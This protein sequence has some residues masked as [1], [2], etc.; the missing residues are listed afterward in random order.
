MKTAGSKQRGPVFPQSD[1]VIFYRPRPKRTSERFSYTP[2][3]YRI[4][5]P[6][7]L[8][9]DA[10]PSHDKPAHDGPARNQISPSPDLAALCA[11]WV[12]LLDNQ[13]PASSS[14]DGCE[15]LL[16]GC[17]DLYYSGRRRYIV[18]GRV[19]SNGH[20]RSSRKSAREDR[21][22]LFI[23]ERGASNQAKLCPLFRKYQLSPREQEVVRLL[24]EDKSYQEIATTLNLSIHTVKVYLKS[25]M[26][27]LGVGSRAGVISC[28]FTSF[29]A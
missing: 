5:A 11:R 27:K 18:T 15:A 19:L 4:L 7:H 3:A 8:S 24:L 2:E 21:H 20:A 25:L 13:G 1:A 29:F 9:S 28:L 14:S 26:R 6:I 12:Q 10:I 16:T 23:L 22:Y 17:L